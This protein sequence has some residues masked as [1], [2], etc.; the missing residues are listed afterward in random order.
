LKKYG[1]HPAFY[2]FEP[3]NEPWWASDF[4]VLKNF[5]RTIRTEMQKLTPNAIFV[6]HD[7]FQ[8]NHLWDD[9]FAD[10]DLDK[11]VMDHHQYQAWATNMNTT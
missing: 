6:F 4:D 10:N 3:V 1:K 9:L 8:Y 2:A 7:G 11:V 5:Y